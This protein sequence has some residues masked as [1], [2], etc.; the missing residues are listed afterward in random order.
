MILTISAWDSAGALERNVDF[1]SARRYVNQ[2][3]GTGL[4]AE[5]TGQTLTLADLDRPTPTPTLPPLDLEND[6]TQLAPG[7][8]GLGPVV[9]IGPKE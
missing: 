6:V 4:L 7:G 5:I 2:L 3:E 1:S 8:A 9:L